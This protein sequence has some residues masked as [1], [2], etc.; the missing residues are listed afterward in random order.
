MSNT[1]AGLSMLLTLHLAGAIGSGL[2]QTSAPHAAATVVTNADIQAVIAAAPEG[3]VSDVQFR[4]V[5]AGGYNVGIGVVQRPASAPGGAIQHANQTEIYRVVEGSGTLVTGGELID[6][7]PLDPEGNVVTQLTGPSS[8]GSGIRGG[9]TRQVV[10][11]DMV[12]IPAGV[13]HGFSELFEDIT[14]LVVRVDPEQLVE[15][16]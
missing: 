16:K 11:G 2:P 8:Y 4:M 5:D 1:I 10:A 9:E 15:L 12:I 14:Y 13:A 6:S 7:Q 3:R